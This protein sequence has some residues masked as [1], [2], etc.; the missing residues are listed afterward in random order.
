MMNRYRANFPTQEECFFAELAAGQRYV[1][2][3]GLANGVS[4]TVRF[5]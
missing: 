4:T 3:H 1:I 2:S 5:R